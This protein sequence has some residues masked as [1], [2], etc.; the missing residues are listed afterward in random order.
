MYSMYN[1]C[2]C[3]ATFGGVYTSVKVWPH[4]R[5]IHVEL[6]AAIVPLAALVATKDKHADMPASYSRIFYCDIVGYYNIY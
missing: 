1:I 4:G 2:T 5:S 6:V 3:F